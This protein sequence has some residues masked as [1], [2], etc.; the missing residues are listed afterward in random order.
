[1]PLARRCNPRKRRLFSDGTHPFPVPY[2]IRDKATKLRFS[3]FAG[4]KN[5]TVGGA[6][7]GAAAPK[8]RR[9]ADLLNPEESQTTEADGAKRF[10]PNPKI[11][12]RHLRRLPVAESSEPVEPKEAG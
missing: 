4:A 2:K 12:A 6:F 1:M 8:R 7:E 9:D 3:D 5:P 10:S 11:Q